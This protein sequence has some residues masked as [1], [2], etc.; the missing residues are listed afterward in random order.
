M[1]TISKYI[2][3]VNERY[4]GHGQSVQL[5]GINLKKYNP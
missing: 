2:K 4:L 3:L 1:M 5:D